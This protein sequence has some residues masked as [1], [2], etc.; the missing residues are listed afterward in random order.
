MTHVLVTGGAGFV[1]SHV[2]DHLVDA[3]YDVTVVD[4]LTD[5]VHDGKPEY[6]NDDATYVWGDVR[7]R[8]L[9]TDLL[10]EADVLN[11]QASAVGVG[12]SMYEIERYVE[13][14]TLA[15]AR[16]LD[17]LVTE[18]IDLEKLVVASSMSL[19]GEGAYYCPDCDAARYP[20]R[21]RERDMADGV[22]E[23]RCERCEGAL[24][25]RPTSEEKPLDSTSVYAITKRDQ[26]DLCRAV[27]RAYDIPTVALRYFN[28]YGS[29]QSLD[30]PYTGVC[31]IFSSRIKNGNPPLLFEDGA[32]SRDFVHVS[33]VA[34]ANVAAVEAPI[35]DEAINVGTGNPHTIR[36][37]ADA[38]IDE[39]GASDTVEPE[40]ADDFRAGD[41][42]HCYADT[43]R[44]ERL[45]EFTA[46][47]SLR[48]G[49]EELVGWAE[50]REAEDNFEDAHD[51]LKQRGLIRDS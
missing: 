16:L 28:I 21:R 46:S 44:A 35:A 48:D 2:V 11:H 15:T 47:V 13:V 1:G 22:W 10:T 51:E 25:A 41:I 20:T 26:E 6:L 30:N 32:Q 45:L 37:I 36:D 3:G 14:N 43:S 24:E 33:D 7:D 40:V 27:G 42:R 23:H 12:Q 50:T 4:N 29:R 17:I 38:L 34:R 18:E 8:D 31:A 49:I 5:Q 9:M 19:Y 39:Y